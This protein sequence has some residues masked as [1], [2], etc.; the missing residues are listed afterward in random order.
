MLFEF[1]IS[2]PDGFQQLNGKICRGRAQGRQGLDESLADA[3]SRAGGSRFYSKYAGNFGNA[4]KSSGS[5]WITTR[6]LV[7]VAMRS[8]RSNDA[9]A[10]AAD[11]TRGDMAISTASAMLALS[12]HA[13]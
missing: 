3:A 12:A 4:L 2:L 10:S 6:A 8:K 7:L 5:C 11:D 9:S 1:R 13:A